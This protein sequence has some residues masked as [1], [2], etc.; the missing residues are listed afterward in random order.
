MTPQHVSLRPQWLGLV[1][2][3]CGVVAQAQ[4]CGTPGLTSCRGVNTAAWTG[5]R[6]G[7][8]DESNSNLAL[9]TTSSTVATSGSIE[10]RQIEQV[11][12][13]PGFAGSLGE[14]STDPASYGSGP[15]SAILLGHGQGPGTL[16]S[17]RTET[18]HAAPPLTSHV[19]AFIGQA[20]SGVLGTAGPTVGPNNLQFVT[21]GR[22]DFGLN[23]AGT[24]VSGHLIEDQLLYPGNAI[25]PDLSGKAKVDAHAY[26]QSVWTDNLLLTGALDGNVT[27]TVVVDGALTANAWVKYQLSV[28]GVGGAAILSTVIDGAHSPGGSSQTLIGTLEV[29]GTHRI[30]ITGDL[31]ARVDLPDAYN[32]PR[33]TDVLAVANFLSTARITDIA[34]SPGLVATYE[35]GS[36]NLA[37]VTHVSGV[38]EPAAWLLMLAASPLLGWRLTRRAGKPARSPRGGQAHARRSVSRQP[39]P[40]V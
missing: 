13:R 30:Q 3:L 24:W 22:T 4:P 11:Y 10:V 36:A 16:A 38:P 17:Y 26:T 29:H 27:F 14:V 35:S 32:D 31:M 8:S 23:R 12:K 28:G 37:N 15:G 6:I 40:A 9:T 34:L 19:Q 21:D 7:W 33:G 25:K 20:T 39:A 18:D 2:A 5:A 1:A